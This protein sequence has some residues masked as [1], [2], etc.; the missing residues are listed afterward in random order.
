MSFLNFAS[1][2]CFILFQIIIRMLPI[3][4]DVAYQEEIRRLNQTL[5]RKR[6]RIRMELNLEELSETRFKELFRINKALF[7]FLCEELTPYL[8][9]PKYL[10]GVT[11]QQKVLVA[12]RFYA[13]GSYQ[14][15]VGG[16]FNL[17]VSQ[18]SVHRYVHEVT[19]AINDNLT[20]RT[21]KFPTTRREMNIVKENFM[22]KFQFPGVVGAIDCTQIAILKPN[23][24]E[25]NYINR[26]GYHSL[27]VQ[28]ICDSD[29][30]I[31]SINAN[32]PGSTH[33]SFIWRNS[34]V[35]NFLLTQY[36]QGLRRTWLLGDSGYP[37]EPVLM[38]PYQN[39]LE[40]SSESHYNQN[41][42][43]ARN[44]IERTNGVLKARFRCLL[45][46]RV[47]RYAPEFVGKLVNTCCVLHNLCITFGIEHE[48]NDNEEENDILQ[49]IGN[50]NIMGNLGAREGEA[51]RRSI[52]NTYFNI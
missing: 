1:F 49:N 51:I 27:N 25:H 16:D 4:R 41:H 46:E 29:L 3:F 38:T 11:V 20:A 36:R 35:K 32:Y 21:I 10:S 15:S 31:L 42:I 28:L 12:L 33:D 24:E 17:G 37:L 7:R 6:R 48:E 52:V 2:I 9:Q 45:K 40:G 19:N 5:R 13:T 22:Q 23:N 18:T 8:R 43:R 30:K 50:Q 47:A 39:P 44:C 34:E 26:K 14:R